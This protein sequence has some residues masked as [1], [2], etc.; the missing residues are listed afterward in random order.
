MDE[1]WIIN[2]YG[3]GFWVGVWSLARG[4]WIGV[5]SYHDFSDIV[6][7]AIITGIGF[8]IMVI[9]AALLVIHVST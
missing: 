9:S 1:F 4:I 5:I 7:G 3:L 6:H 8:L 2:L